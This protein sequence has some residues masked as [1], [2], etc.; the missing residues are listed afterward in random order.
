MAL[1]Y[2]TNSSNALFRHG[3]GQIINL[4]N[5]LRNWPVEPMRRDVLC[6]YVCLC[7]P[8]DSEHYEMS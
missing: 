2:K 8:L 3:E 5:D 1:F 4:A 6:L 7:Q